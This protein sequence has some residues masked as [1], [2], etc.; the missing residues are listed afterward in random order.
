MLKTLP[1]S[2]SR[3]CRQ[4][5]ILN[6][7]QPYRPPRSVTGLTLL[8][9]TKPSQI[10]AIRK[11]RQLCGA[12]SC[13]LYPKSVITSFCSN[14]CCCFLCLPLYCKFWQKRT[15]WVQIVTLIGSVAT[16]RITPLLDRNKSRTES[17][18]TEALHLNCSGIGVTIVLREQADV[19]VP[20]MIMHEVSLMGNT[21][22]VGVEGGCICERASDSP[23]CCVSSGTIFIRALNETSIPFHFRHVLGLNRGS[24]QLQLLKCRAQ[25]WFCCI[26]CKTAS[27]V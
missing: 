11:T 19:I 8:Y 20:C 9:F 7:L 6:M 24:Y 18:M 21:P 10:L 5:G 12:R 25:N 23:L 2:V 4:C 16:V 15:G 13:P 1:P 3:L 17:S 14:L 26:S 22:G 27:V